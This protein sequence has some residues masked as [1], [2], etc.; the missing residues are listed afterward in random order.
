MK[1]KLREPINALTHFAG[2]L[3]SLLGLGLLLSKAIESADATRILSSVVFSI[4]L[5]AL[6]MTS[7]LYHGMFRHLTLM[8]RLDHIMLYFLIAASY[9]PICLI[10]LKGPVGTAMVIVIWSLAIAGTVLKIIWM[11]APRWLYTGFYLLMG[12][13]AL[14]VLFPLHRQLPGAAMA[15]LVSG[16]LLYSLGAILYAT[17]SKRVRIGHFGFHE[18]FHLLIL[19]GSLNH[20]IMIYRFV[21]H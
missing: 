1:L 15:L 16:G 14:F 6:Y 4:G 17:K 18:I 5:F 19:L 9:T 13:A 11:N 20:F 3:L 8:R 7:A 12:W 2:A 10:T 21:I